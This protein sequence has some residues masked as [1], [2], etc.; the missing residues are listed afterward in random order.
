LNLHIYVS[1]RCQPDKRL[2]IFHDLL[3]RLLYPNAAGVIVQ[4][5][6]AKETYQRLLP[7]TKLIVIGNPIRAIPTEPEAKREN[8]VL[9]VGMLIRSKNFDALIKLFAKIN[10]PDWKLVIVGDDVHKQQNKVK[11]QTLV[12]ELKYE[13]KVIFAGLR[14]DV[15]TFYRKSKISA[16]TSSSEGFPNVIGEAMS[17][18]LPVI[19]FDCTAGPSEMITDGKDGYLIP[20]N[21]YSLFQERLEQLMVDTQLRKEMGS[22]A[23]E[24]I[25]KFSINNIG[26]KYFSFIMGK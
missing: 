11:L 6:K 12:K 8:I 25:Q 5:S 16:F 23:I 17:A 10:V 14:S 15:D 24:S 21:D 18:G 2:G 19:S 7:N 13:D 20:V 4:T 1:D 22:K 3:R 26:A 9:S